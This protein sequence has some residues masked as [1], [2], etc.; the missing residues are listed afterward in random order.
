MKDITAE[1]ARGRPE[2]AGR[3]DLLDALAESLGPPRLIR[4]VRVGVAPELL[5]DAATVR[6]DLVF[7]KPGHKAEVRD[8]AHVSLEGHRGGL[9]LELHVDGR[10]KD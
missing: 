4:S 6:V 1:L 3:D 2:A 9:T 8:A 10:P 7:E 5:R